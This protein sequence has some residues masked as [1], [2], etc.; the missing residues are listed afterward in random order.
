[1]IEHIGQAALLLSVGCAAL[2]IQRDLWTP[3][4]SDLRDRIARKARARREAKEARRDSQR[5]RQ[6][7]REAQERDRA[8]VLSRVRR[9]VP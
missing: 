4:T 9:W 2:W 1:M 6:A 3:W 8:A 5:A 7:L